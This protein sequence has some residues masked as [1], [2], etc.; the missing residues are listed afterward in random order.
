MRYLYRKDPFEIHIFQIVQLSSIDG[1]FQD[2]YSSLIRLIKC[3]HLQAKMQL[4]GSNRVLK[5]SCA[6]FIF[7]VES[8]HTMSKISIWLILIMPLHFTKS[9]CLFQSVHVFFFFSKSEKG[10]C[11]T[12]LRVITFTC[13]YAA[14]NAMQGWPRT[15]NKCINTSMIL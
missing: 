1:S 10:Y 13:Y 3:T 2:V 12:M 8:F 7:H 4:Q 14:R 11:R 9:R 6:W 15:S 5:W